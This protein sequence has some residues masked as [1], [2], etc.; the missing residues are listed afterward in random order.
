[1]DVYALKLPTGEPYLAVTS[2]ALT[3]FENIKRAVHSN[4]VRPDTAE[5]SRTLLSPLSF[6][7]HVIDDYRKAASRQCR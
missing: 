4:K 2:L 5:R 1:M 6:F 3:I 7:D